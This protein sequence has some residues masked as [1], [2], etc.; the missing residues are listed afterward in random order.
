MDH[1]IKKSH[2]VHIKVPF[3][4]LDPFQVVWHGNYLKYF[5]VAREALFENLGVDLYSIYSKTNYIF[6]VIKTS[7]KHV[8]PLKHGDEII[9]KATIVDVG[10]KI[11]TE[12]EIR[13][14]AD[15]RLCARG[16]CEQVAIKTPEME[17]M[18]RIP[19]EICQAIGL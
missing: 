11:V 1:S 6:P 8:F 2:D 9:C 5:E 14:A 19:E 12:Y 10:I 17:T 16:K 7:T 15:G 4:D 13:L 18:Y 3:Y